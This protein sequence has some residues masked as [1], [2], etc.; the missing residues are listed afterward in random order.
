MERAVGIPSKVVSAEA[1]CVEVLTDASILRTE[2][3]RGG[4]QLAGVEVNET[5]VG[6]ALTADNA[7][8]LSLWWEDQGLI[9]PPSREYVKLLALV[10]RRK[11]APFR[12]VFLLSMFVK[13]RKR[14]LST[15]CFRV[16]G[17]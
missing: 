8:E 16:K 13:K 6:V 15:S 1:A 4:K 7:L 5:L 12:S 2:E 3:L 9:R 11:A 10:P 17:L 14:D